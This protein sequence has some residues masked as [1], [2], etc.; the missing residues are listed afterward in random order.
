MNSYFSDSVIDDETDLPEI[1]TE[2]IR[3][4]ENLMLSSSI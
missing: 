3:V 1:T 4:D 2:C